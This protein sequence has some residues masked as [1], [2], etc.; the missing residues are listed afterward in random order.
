MLKISNTKSAKPRKSR[1][2]IVSNGKNKYN[3]R[4][5]LD[6]RSKLGNCKIDSNKVEDNGV[7]EE[8]NY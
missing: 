8:K 5:K 7:V 3:G 1:V 2:K 6:D 4:V